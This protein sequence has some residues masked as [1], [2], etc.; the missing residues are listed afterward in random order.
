MICT[1]HPQPLLENEGSFFGQAAAPPANLQL[2]SLGP[3]R[4]A[5]QDN[6]EGLVNA[7]NN[8]QPVNNPNGLVN[9]LNNKQPVNNPDKDRER[10]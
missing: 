1:N 2:P 9:A 7:I 4:A 6:P 8:R 10:L 3:E 5:W